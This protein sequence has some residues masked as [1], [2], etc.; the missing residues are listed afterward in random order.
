MVFPNS[1]IM[2]RVLFKQWM[3]IT[4]TPI[5]G[6]LSGHSLGILL[7]LLRRAWVRRNKNWAD[8]TI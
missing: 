1:G 8:L 6:V 2:I 5:F 3:A 4:K 7:K